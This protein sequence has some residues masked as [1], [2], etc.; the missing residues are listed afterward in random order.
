MPTPIEDHAMNDNIRSLAEMRRRIEE[1]N[2]L[3]DR[4]KIEAHRMRA[5]ALSDFVVN[6]DALVRDA[7]H[8]T[9]RAASRLAARLRQHAKQRAVEV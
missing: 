6:A 9:A 3:R 2:A 8:R 1:Q 4:A 7:A 5:E